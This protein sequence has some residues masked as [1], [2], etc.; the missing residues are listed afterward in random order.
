[1]SNTVTV[2]PE[3]TMSTHIPPF[4]MLRVVSLG[5]AVATIPKTMVRQ[6]VS[7]LCIIGRYQQSSGM[8]S[9]AADRDYYLL[10]R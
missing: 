6:A 7:R 3:E 4:R 5:A 2:N 8:V 9:P 1:M 10:R